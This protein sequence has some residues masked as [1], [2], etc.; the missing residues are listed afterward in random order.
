MYL[1]DVLFH[2][3]IVPIHAVSPYVGLLRDEFSALHKEIQCNAG[4]WKMYIISHAEKGG[5]L[6]MRS[7]GILACSLAKAADGRE[8]PY[9]ASWPLN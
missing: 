7:K 2:P 5:K 8:P 3:I 1:L 4:R 6:T 9:S